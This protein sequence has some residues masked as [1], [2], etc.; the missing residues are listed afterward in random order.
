MR[1]K[2]TV[3]IVTTLEDISC[4]GII[5]TVLEEAVNEIRTALSQAVTGEGDPTDY[6][7][8]TKQIREIEAPAFFHALVEP[9][10]M[11]TWL[12]VMALGTW[13]DLLIADPFTS[14]ALS[15][16][17]FRRMKDE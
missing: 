1:A 15:A 2:D 8:I 6:V 11:P 7:V 17:W 10:P 13:R 12:R 4:D 14:S 16:E 3:Y 5:T 9:S